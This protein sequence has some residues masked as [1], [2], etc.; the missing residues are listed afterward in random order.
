M[1][2]NAANRLTVLAAMENAILQNY[3][4][5]PLMNNASAALKGMKIEYFTEDE[6]FP[7][8]RGGVKYMSFNY[9]DAAWTAYVAEQ[10]GTLNYK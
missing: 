8:A 10:G 2:D 6:V 9:D 7:M 5:I 1:G 4:F 3:D